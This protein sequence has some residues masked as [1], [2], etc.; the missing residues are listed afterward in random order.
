M[1]SQGF[2]ETTVVAASGRL[3]GVLLLIHYFLPLIVGWSLAL[4]MHQA[5]G[6]EFSPFGLTLL[7]AGIG[8]AYS[9]DRLIDDAPSSASRP[10][11]LHQ[12][13][14]WGFIVCACIIFILLLSIKIETSLVAACGILSVASLLYSCLKRTPMVKTLGVSIVWIWACSTLPFAGLHDTPTWAWLETGTTLPLLLLLC[15]NCILCDLKDTVQDRCSRIPSLPVLVGARWACLVATCLA[16]ASAGTA[17][18]HHCVSVVIASVLLAAA[19]QFPTLLSRDP[20]GPIV[21]DSILVV[22][23]VLILTG[24]V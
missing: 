18:I 10:L 13:L 19:A 5:T 4:V 1:C 7:L 15:A 23:G 14:R 16:L 8:A 6:A 21:I 20:I 24:I 11:W 12:T 2:Q 22:S 17:A 9:F 3:R